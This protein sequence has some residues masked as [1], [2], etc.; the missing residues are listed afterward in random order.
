[1]SWGDVGLAAGAFVLMEPITAVLH[2]TLFHGPG[3]LLHRSHHQPTGTAFEANDLFPVG[4]A[5]V[6]ILAMA[7]GTFADGLVAL[8]PVGVGVT[9][10]GAAYAAVHDLYIHRR[11]DVLPRHV[12]GL[13]HLRQAHGL[14]HRFDGAPYGMLAPVVPARIRARARAAD[15]T[16]AAATLRQVEMR[17]RVEKTS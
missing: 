3:W 17:A 15:E 12:R 4:F 6:T 9:A 10:Y 16:A 8:V 11:V 13:E 1:M 5:A 14:H 2:R 7:L